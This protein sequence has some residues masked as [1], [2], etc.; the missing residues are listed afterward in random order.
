[1]TNTSKKINQLPEKGTKKTQQAIKKVKS[2]ASKT[3]QKIDQA[4]KNPL[5]KK[6]K[7]AITETTKIATSHL[8]ALKTSLI[9]S[10]Q[11]SEL[12]IKLQAELN[13]QEVYPSKSE[14]IRA[15]L[16]NLRNKKPEELEEIIKDLVKVKQMRVL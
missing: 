13:K 12:I 9:L 14:I 5:G 10:N 8:A 15:G 3:T 1:M 2:V 16:W 4:Q 11:E 7:K 6:I